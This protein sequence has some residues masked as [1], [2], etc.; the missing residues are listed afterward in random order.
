LLAKLA[1]DGVTT[2]DVKTILQGK[3]LVP[4]PLS[5]DSLLGA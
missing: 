5:L 3:Q 2:A 4:R 1:H